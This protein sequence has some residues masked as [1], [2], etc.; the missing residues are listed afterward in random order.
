[1]RNHL[2]EMY[3]IEDINYFWKQ[4]Q[5]VLDKQGN[6]VISERHL[7]VKSFNLIAFPPHFTHY[8]CDIWF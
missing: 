1:M 5:L 6:L 7:Q 4:G 3:V 8:Y 2:L